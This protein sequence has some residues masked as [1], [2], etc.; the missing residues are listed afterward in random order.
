[1]PT[2][3]KQLKVINNSTLAKDGTFSIGLRDNLVIA[4]QSKV[5]LSK[6]LYQETSALQT[7][8]NLEQTTFILTPD[9]IGFPLISQRTP[10][11]TIVIPKQIFA[12]V[13]QLVQKMNVLCNNSLV[14]GDTVGSKTFSDFVQ[15]KFASPTIDCGF[16]ILFQPNGTDGNIELNFLSN[17]IQMALGDANGANT[18]P[19]AINIVEAEDERGDRGF[20]PQ[21]L[22]VSWGLS[23]INQIVKGAFQSYIQVNQE[24]MAGVDWYFGLRYSTES[25]SGNTSPV[26]MGIYKDTDSSY[27]LVDEGIVKPTA[28]DYTF[29]AGDFFVLFTAQGRLYLQIFNGATDNEGTTGVTTKVYQSPPF[30]LYDLEK[31]SFEVN[32][33]PTVAKGTGNVENPPLPSDYPY[34]RQVYWTTRDLQNQ[35]DNTLYPPNGLGRYVELD[36]SQ[37]GELANW[38]GLPS[39]LLSSPQRLQLITFLGTQVPNFYRVQDLALFWSLPAQTY[40]GNQTKTRN[41]REN[42]IASFTPSRQLTSTDNLFFQEQLEYTDIGNLDTMNISTIQFRVI[43]EFPNGNTP[44]TTNYISFVLFIKEEY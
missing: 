25:F 31:E 37:S 42:M 1:M 35:V 13:T 3:I 20:S 18:L 23:D 30:T 17:K 26:R 6:F 14:C 4:P 27:Y 15:Q 19:V 10:P 12:N 36:L 22:F 32:Y 43:N 34:F 39:L 40:V 29:T 8:I 24:G 7:A 2:R 16:D 33:R 28:I 41:G 9:A 5:A 21:A 44:I 11:R 38:L